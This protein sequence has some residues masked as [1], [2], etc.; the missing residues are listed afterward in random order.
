[1]I[2]FNNDEFRLVSG[3]PACFLSF[4][5]LGLDILCFSLLLEVLLQG[6]GEALGLSVFMFRTRLSSV[7]VI[8]DIIGAIVSLLVLILLVRLMNSMI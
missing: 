7:R 2:R 5:C 4:V 6:V 1:M 3:S 8:I